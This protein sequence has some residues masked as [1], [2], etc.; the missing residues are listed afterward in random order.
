MGSAT[1]QGQLWGREP[2]AW[3]TALE[4]LMRPLYEATLG[5]LGPLDGVRLLDAGCGAG[6]ALQCA[7]DRGATVSGTDA[8]APLLEVARQRTPAADLRTA[9]IEELPHDD[10]A[11][12]VVTAFNSIQ[13]AADPVQ[14]VTELARVV[15]PG[16]RVAVGVWA[17]PSRC[18]TEA[19]F[20]RL[21]SLAPPPPGTAAP[22]AA[23]EPGVVEGL[24][25]KAGLHVTGGGEVVCPFTFTD[26]E[27]A[28]TAHTSAGPL[29]K[30][31]DIAGEQAVRTT[32]HDV[33]EADR[34]PDGELRQDNSFRYVMATKPVQ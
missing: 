7:A 4:P 30:V 12:D 6:L 13:Y 20:A 15:R 3:S 28:F 16:G 22:L 29:Q 33:L 27:A 25:E 2:A 18:E 11:F 1:V 9:D 17:E 23:S 14:A 8:A 31:L 34:K 32:I 19:L 24:L 21:R 10:G 26:H 5:A